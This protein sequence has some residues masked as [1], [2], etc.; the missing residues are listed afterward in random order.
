[1]NPVVQKKWLKYGVCVLLA[2]ITG[3]AFAGVAGHAFISFD[4]MDYTINNIHIQ[5]GFTWKVIKW[6]FTAVYASNWHPLTWLSH[7]LDWNF[8][9]YDPA[10]PHLVNLAFHIAN[11]VLLFLLLQNITSKL[12]PSAFAAMLFGIHPMHVESVSWVAE[13]K[14]MLSTFF[15]LLTLLAYARYT[16][17]VR[18]KKPMRW[19]VFGLALLLFALGLMS[20]PMLVTVPGIL[21][22]MDW[23][24]LKR[25]EL[26]L[27]PQAKSVL[28]RLGAEKVPFILLSVLCC[29]VTYAAQNGSG[30]VKQSEL[31]PLGQRLGHL[32]VAYGWYVFKVFWPVNL[33]VYHRLPYN[34]S[35]EDFF[36]P[37]LFLLF[38]T[39]FVIWR[40]RKNPYLFM[41]WFW[42]LGTLVPVIGVVQVGNQ[43]YADRYTYIPYIGLFIGLAW[44]IPE[45]FAK[46][47]SPQRAAV[48]WTG[49][50]LLTA[51]CFWR[52]VDEVGY[53]ENGRTLFQRAIQLN[54]DNEMAWLNLGLDYENQARN[55]LAIKDFTEATTLNDRFDLGWLSLGKA[56]ALIKDYPG[57]VDALQ[58]AVSAT[59]FSGDKAPIY[60]DLGDVYSDLGQY[61]EAIASYQN[62]LDL[63]TNQPGAQTKLG[64][65]Y[66]LIGQTN[67]AA[68][69][70]QTAI[71]LDP[72]DADAHLGLAMLRQ[73]EGSDAEA[74]VQ[75]RKVV[76]LDTNVVIAL[77]NLAWL[78]AADGDPKLRNG[79]A[80]VPLAEHAC[81][82]THYRQAFFIGTLADAYA[83]AGRFNDAV[84]AAKQAHDVALAQGEQE[85]ADRNAQ[86]MELYRSGHAYHMDTKLPP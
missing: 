44:G 58:R 63:D 25:F 83:E 27:K 53:W 80:A 40:L 56:R 75:F 21:C 82:R 4:D 12:W 50:A 16:E 33:S 59:W 6:A 31:Y 84:A 11:T 76:E 41:G 67:Q 48:L 57:A 1:M 29:Y 51:V 22:L 7:T 46:L 42:F 24:P 13:R 23:W 8:F 32:P 2:A 9:A 28:Y 68:A 10:G 19:A 18:D 61:D 77:N 54:P 72:N 45:L 78:L 73:K 64:Q 26:S 62:S 39:A 3:A 30:A 81:D 52:T 85:L 70:F 37:T 38:V 79:Q 17:L 66:V 20:K 71:T 55:D 74:I 65:T 35:D 14:D 49:A 36:G 47:P 43:S 15:L 86:L 60:I 69:A 34:M 5:Q